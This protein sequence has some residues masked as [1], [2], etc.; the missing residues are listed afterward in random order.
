MTAEP[1]SNVGT[2]ALAIRAG[3]VSI[4]PIDH[5]TKRPLARLLP[6]DDKGKPVW[7]PYQRQIVD[8]AVAAGWFAAGARSFAVV[9]GAISGGLLI[10]DFDVERFYHAWTSAVGDLAKGLPLQ[11]TGGG[12][13]QV[14][15]RCPNPGGNDK[16][17]W[18]E[19]E[20][21]DS[22][23][24]IAIETRGEGGYAVVPPSLHPDGTYYQMLSGDLAHIPAIPQAQ[25]DA[26]LAASRKLD[27]CPLTRQERQRLEQQAHQAHQRRA[28]ASRNG[29]T[30]VIGQFNTAH[31]IDAL[32]E[33]HGYTKSGDRFVRP[34]GTSA[35]VSVKDGRSCHFSSDDPLND[36]KVKSG[37][38]IHDAF[39]IY[40]YFEHA[41][42]VRAAVKA[43]AQLLGIQAPASASAPSAASAGDPGGDGEGLIPL[44]TR[45]PATKKLVLSPKKTLPTAEA[46]VRE[47]HHHDDGRKLHSYAGNIMVW[48]GNRFVEI[49]E[50]GLRQQFQPW[51]HSALRYQYNRET[52][53]LELVDFESNPTTI[54]A[55]VESLRAYTH[56]PAVITPPTWLGD[57]HAMPDP[58][59]LLPFRSGTLH[60]PTGD[61]LLP[62]P[63]L[64]NI[65]ALDFDYNA[66]AP[67][68]ELWLAFLKQ[69]WEN[70]QESIDLLQE[71]MGYCLVADTSQQKML[72]IVGP[73][74]SGKGT[75]G[76]ILTRLVGAGNVIG[77]TTSSLAGS[78]G[79]QPLIGK[80]LAIV[81]DARFTGE[82]VVVVVERLLCISGEDTLTV[83]RKYLGAVTMKLPTRF[84]FLTNEVPRMNDA[85]GALAGRFVVLALTRSFYDQEDV[86]LTSKL[87][88]E[89][90]GILLWAVDGLTRLRERGHFV[91]PA[92]V[93]E[94]VRDMEDLAS[95]VLAFVRDR[96][97]VAPGHR[98]WVDDLYAAWKSWCEQDGRTAIITKHTFGRDLAAACPGVRRRRGAGDVPFYEGINLK[99]SQPC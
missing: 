50:E 88:A 23:R 45:D 73:K 58:R 56:L 12:G 97:V 69:L 83:D 59:E 4:L 48:R 65:N 7:E 61:V 51:L 3:G 46:F 55:A 34:G 16:L 18:V 20:A 98:I 27:E 57:A 30:D 95:P 85:S 54:N 84:V 2:P 38:G 62:T 49:E 64:F 60:V 80:S 1:T 53:E 28:V 19:N 29:N 32:L 33:Q 13:F 63:G 89:L 35:S 47:F 10:L 25:A 31:A 40:A 5:R 43:S 8:E 66:S 79:L 81:S 42:D 90:P 77:P 99:G 14:F 96:C 76:R 52:R 74:R 71:W 75:I 82:N 26:L 87:M 39:D 9:G 78:F 68:P 44:G 37:V 17:A 94:A 11:R 67:L 22:G 91:Q 41:G 36:G 72:L 6:R 70:D 15:C 24:S 21:E 93:A 92:A 86:A